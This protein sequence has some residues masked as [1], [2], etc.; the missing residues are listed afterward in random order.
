MKKLLLLGGICITSFFSAEAQVLATENFDSYVNGN[1]TTAIDGVTPGQGSYAFQSSN[2]A[3]PTTST[4]ANVNQ[5]QIVTAPSSTDRK[6]QLT[7]PNGN[8]GGS[9]LYKNGLAAAWSGRTSGNN[10]FEVEFDINTGGP[11][12]SQNRFGIYVY[13]AT[14]GKILAGA[15]VQANNKQILATIFSQ[16]TGAPAAANYSYTLIDA[17]ENPITLPSNAVSRIGVSFNKT[18]GQLRIKGPGIDPAGITIQGSALTASDPVEID[19]VAFSGGTTTG[20]NPVPNTAASMMTIDNLSAKASSTDT[21]LGLENGVLASQFAVFPNPASN[22]VTVSGAEA[23]VDAIELIDLNGRTVKSVKVN[24]VAE[25]QI[26][27]SDL[28]AGVY[29][30]NISSDKGK[31]TKKIV[32]Q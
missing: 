28:S 18:T 3:A 30:M 13:D 11:T 4:N 5:A 6:L 29:M 23:L 21:L 24:G 27:I 26:N 14:F 20:T 15:L 7:G 8:K 22:V 12:T 2:G 9:F 25:A 10:I 17:S 31:T 19:F 1:V 32:K 16:P